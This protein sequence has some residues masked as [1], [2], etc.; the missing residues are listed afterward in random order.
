MNYSFANYR[1]WRGLPGLPLLLLLLGSG[2]LEGDG[3]HVVVVAAA[4]AVAAGEGYSTGGRKASE[5][6][7]R[8]GQGWR[9]NAGVTEIVF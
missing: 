5:G 7:D 6:W 2:D 9:T 1:S 4:A 3:G 8:S